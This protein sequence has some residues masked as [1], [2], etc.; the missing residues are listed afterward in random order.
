MR[1]DPST[2]ISTACNLKKNKYFKILENK[3]ADTWH[4][5]LNNILLGKQ[6]RNPSNYER[7][8]LYS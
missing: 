2:N 1:K 8:L 6:E 7:R 5:V 4:Y 3:R